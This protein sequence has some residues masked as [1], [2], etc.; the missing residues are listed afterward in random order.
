MH[1]AD[2]NYLM[3][4]LAPGS[5]DVVIPEAEHHVMIDQPLAF[6]AAVR[7]LLVA[8]PAERA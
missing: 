8:W 5:P 4:L 3:S 6:V 1:A 7:A 2:A